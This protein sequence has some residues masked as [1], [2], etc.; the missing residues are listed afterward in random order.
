MA[1]ENLEVEAEENRL[2]LFRFDDDD[3]NDDDDDVFFFEFPDAA[4]PVALALSRVWNW[5]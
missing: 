2:L 4:G 1:F 3:D 5:S